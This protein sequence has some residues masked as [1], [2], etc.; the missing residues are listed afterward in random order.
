VYNIMSCMNVK[1]EEIKKIKITCGRN[2]YAVLF[3]ANNWQRNNF[4]SF[5]GFGLVQCSV[6]SSF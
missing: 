3:F 4:A 1:E 2:G 6:A 5:N